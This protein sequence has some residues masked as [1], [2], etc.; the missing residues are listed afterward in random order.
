[1]YGVIRYCSGRKLETGGAV[2]DINGAQKTI[3]KLLEYVQSI[4]DEN[5]LMYSKSKDKLRDVATT[6]TEVVSLISAILQD[7]ILEYD[8]S[9]FESG[10]PVDSV[11]DNIQ[12]QITKLRKFAGS[13]NTLDAAKVTS[14]STTV[15]RKQLLFN[16]KQVM[17]LNVDKVS[18]MDVVDECSKLLW[19]WFEVR[20]VTT[21]HSSQFK[22]NIKRI[23]LWIRDIVILYGNA[24]N[25]NCRYEFTSEFY[26]WLDALPH[27]D[28][29]N[30][31]A[32]PYE[33]YL[34][35]RT[36]DPASLCL[37]AVVLWDV[38]LSGP[39]SQMCKKNN[40]Y[41]LDPD[42]VYTLCDKLNPSCLD[43]YSDFRYHPEMLEKLKWR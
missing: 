27:S 24:V 41:Y 38:L 12:D 15:N 37:E 6:C 28:G 33:V 20:F 10:S 30:K 21:L 5:P 35:D 1:M 32:V 8:S 18:G 42:A 19:N 43:L 7:K 34:F 4:A 11:L 25:K 2:V 40:P 26:S 29:V 39:L 31:F 3:K 14:D 16:F 17:K 36:P 23:P 22:F 9:E 13:E